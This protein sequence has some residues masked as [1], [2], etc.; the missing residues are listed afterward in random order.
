MTKS[1]TAQRVRIPIG[2]VS[3]VEAGTGTAVV[4]LHGI[5]SAAAS[6]RHQIAALSDRY[7]AIAWNAPGYGESTPPQKQSPQA[8]DYA[9]ALAGFLDALS[10]T[11]CH[12]VGHS[13]GTLMAASFA[14]NYGDRV[15]SLTLCGASAGLGNAPDKATAMLRERLDDL[16]RLGPRQMAEKRGPRLLGPNATPAM[17]REVINIQAAAVTPDG[18][19]RAA[20]MLANA[21]IFLDLARLRVGLPVQVLYGEDD[22]ITTPDHCRT[23]AA[24]CKVPAHGVAKAGHALYLEN[25]EDVTR[26]LARF[27]DNHDKA[28]QA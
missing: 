5:G 22:A 18:Y 2:H 1:Y 17:I 14:A 7:R 15:M 26:L 6:W 8:V 27:I 16:E 4:M 28:A 3:Y 19:A 23:I 13:L 9:H 12:L 10:V 24:A 20:R 21:D 11:R 25:P